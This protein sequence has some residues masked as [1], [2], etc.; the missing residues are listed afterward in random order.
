MLAIGCPYGDA[1]WD[2]ISVP[3]QATMTTMHS[4]PKIPAQEIAE[5]IAKG[6]AV[7]A[8]DA[9]SEI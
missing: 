2:A 3:M 5:R 6:T 8:L 1:R 9:S 4:Q 7:E